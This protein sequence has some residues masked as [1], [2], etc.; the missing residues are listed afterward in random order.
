MAHTVLIADD[1]LGGVYEPDNQTLEY[2]RRVMTELFI[3]RLQLGFSMCQLAK[4]AKCGRLT[5]YLNHASIALDG[6]NEIM[7]KFGM[8]HPDFDQFTAQCERLKFE[9][10]RLNQV[11]PRSV[12]QAANRP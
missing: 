6:A 12:P 3:C 9:L 2:G 1:F 11:N 4:T 5:A 7:Q 10:E 8:N